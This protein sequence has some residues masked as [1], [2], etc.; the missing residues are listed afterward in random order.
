MFDRELTRSSLLQIE[1][2]VDTVIER[3]SGI[4]DVDDFYCSPQG[5]ITLDAVCM[6]L[7][8]MGEA[9]KNLDKVSHGE[10]LPRYPQLNWSGMMR[11]RDKIAHH[12]FEIDAEVVLLTAKEDIPLVKRIVATMLSDLSNI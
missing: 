10:L 6:N 9:V 4:K 2:L 3:T 11:M 1:A 7:V 5:M 12:Y 8:A